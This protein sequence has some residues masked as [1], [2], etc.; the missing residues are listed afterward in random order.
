MPETLIKRRCRSCGCTDDNCAA[1]IAKTGAPCTWVEDDLCSACAPDAVALE[2]SISED[3]PR[4]VHDVAVILTAIAQEMAEV[5]AVPQTPEGA[6]I[7]ITHQFFAEL[8]PATMTPAEVARWSAIAAAVASSASIFLAGGMRA[9]AEHAAAAGLVAPDGVTPAAAR[10]ALVDA[11]GRPI[12]ST[13]G[14]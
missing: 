5:A 14:V 7:V 8:D 4:E 6:A 10:P 2:Y 3:T 13:G 11:S 9:I 12:S 1:C